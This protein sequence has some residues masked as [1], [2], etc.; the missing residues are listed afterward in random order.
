LLSALKG[1][2]SKL[3]PKQP[4]HKRVE[5]KSNLGFGEIVISFIDFSTE[6]I[7]IGI[8]HHVQILEGTPEE[9]LDKVAIEEYERITVH[10]DG[11]VVT[12]WALSP[13]GKFVAPWDTTKSPL[14]SWDMPWSM[15]QELLWSQ[16]SLRYMQGYFTMPKPISH[17]SCL[18]MPVIFEDHATGSVIYFAVVKPN[19]GTNGLQQVMPSRGQTYVLNSGWPWV[20]VSMSNVKDPGLVRLSSVGRDYR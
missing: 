8:P 7:S 14:A 20:L 5:F 6:G 4:E 13:R 15:R 16:E 9:P 19:D 18:S 10:A 12:H 3:K 2:V 17:K 11:K 1:L